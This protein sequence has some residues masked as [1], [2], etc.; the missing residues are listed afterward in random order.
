MATEMLEVIENFRQQQASAQQLFGGDGVRVAG[1][2][3]PQKILETMEFIKDV[4]DGKKPLSLLREAMTT[5]DFSAL[6]GDIIDRQMLGAYREIEPVWNRFIRR[7]RV[8]SFV[9][10]K[11]Y[12]VDGAEGLLDEVDE[13]EEYPEEALKTASD[14]VTVRKYGKRLDLSWEATINDDLD[15][16]RRNPDR[17]ARSARRTEQYNATGL[18]IDAN[19]PHASLYRDDWGPNNDVSNI[20]PGNPPL[21]FDGLQAGWQLFAD[22]KDEDGQ[23]IVMDMAEL[24]VS[25]ALQIT[26]ENILNATELQ[27]GDTTQADSP[28]IRMNNWM[29]GRV[30]LTVDPYIPYHATAAHGTSSWALFANPDASGRAA[31]ELTFLIGHEDPAL[32]E[33][34]PNARRIGGGGGGVTESFEDDS[35]AIRVR[36]VLGGARFTNTGGWRVTVAS[37]GSG[38]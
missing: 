4:E 36:H 13:R 24:V 10:A 3:D 32:Y 29:K 6:F 17:L 25:P 34:L 5:S 9:N 27:Y 23:P 12:S 16:F 14:E 15:A 22:M 8:R 33:R 37:N 2:S 35:H 31:A 28:V 18:Y 20:I 11:R 7:G 21:S 1:R 30:R 19:G 38:S 26:A